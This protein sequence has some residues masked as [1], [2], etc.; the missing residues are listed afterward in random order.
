MHVGRGEL[1]RTHM[2][3]EG[4]FRLN[5]L[6]S[7]VIGVRKAEIRHRSCTIEMLE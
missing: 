1:V 3:I 2:T 4:Y 5:V 7:Y 6:F